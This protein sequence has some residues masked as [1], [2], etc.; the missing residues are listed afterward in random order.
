MLCLF[1]HLWMPFK[2]LS[3]LTA[4]LLERLL[5]IIAVITIT[6]LWYA[7]L[8]TLDCIPAEGSM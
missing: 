5:S 6:T 2:L 3:Q 7:S 4:V 1:K 8:R